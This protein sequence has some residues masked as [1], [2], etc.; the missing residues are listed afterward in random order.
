[1]PCSALKSAEKGQALWQV[2]QMGLDPFTLCPVP[3]RA[4]GLC[5]MTPIC[6]GSWESGKAQ[7]DLAG[8]CNQE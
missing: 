5:K 1:M 3:P 6:P 7:R 8:P 4:Q 2:R